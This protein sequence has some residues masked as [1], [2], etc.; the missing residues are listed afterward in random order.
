MN[1]ALTETEAYSSWLAPLPPFVVFLGRRSGDRFSRCWRQVGTGGQLTLVDIGQYTALGDR[2]MAQEL[3]QFL[4]VADGELEVARDDTC[5]LVVTS[6]VTGKFEN[7][8]SEILEDGRKVD[9]ST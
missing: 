3:V 6:G 2:D 4:I 7:F 1:P 9:G 5:L 8:G